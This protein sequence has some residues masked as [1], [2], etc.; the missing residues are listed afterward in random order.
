M[1]YN[2]PLAIS[3]KD[4]QDVNCSSCVS[5]RAESKYCTSFVFPE[6]LSAPILL[7]KF[8]LDKPTGTP[9]CQPVDSPT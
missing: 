5:A 4:C 7:S 2:C 9:T 6:N 8:K 3:L 1:V